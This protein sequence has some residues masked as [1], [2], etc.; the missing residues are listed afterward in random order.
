MVRVHEFVTVTYPAHK[1]GNVAENKVV[2]LLLMEVIMLGYSTV[3]E[4]VSHCL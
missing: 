1:I 2:G 4:Q 3:F